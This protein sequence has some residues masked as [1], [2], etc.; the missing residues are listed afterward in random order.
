[1]WLKSVTF[2]REKFLSEKKSRVVDRYRPPITHKSHDAY[3]CFY[4][5]FAWIWEKNKCACF[6]NV[7]KAKEEK[8]NTV[9]NWTPYTWNASFY[10]TMS[11]MQTHSW[12]FISLSLGGKGH[13]FPL[14]LL[15][16]LNKGYKFD[17]GKN[18]EVKIFLV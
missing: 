16:Q 17:L 6:R 18:T 12:W 14:C 15:F 7:L 10:S 3:M 5:F 2:G 4:L 9:V 1:M 11:F 13:N 8:I